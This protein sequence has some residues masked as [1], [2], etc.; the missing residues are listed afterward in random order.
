MS[1]TEPGLGTSKGKRNPKLLFLFLSAIILLGTV[2]GVLYH[3][4]QQSQVKSTTR[5]LTWIPHPEK[6]P[7]WKRDALSACPGAPF[8][9]PTE[10]YIGYLWGDSFRPGHLH[11]GVDIFSGQEPGKM[12]VYAVYQGYLT[13]LPAW[14]SSLI[15]R[16]PH[17]PLRPD[18]QI[19]TYYTHLAGPEGKSYIN[20]NFPP[21]TRDVFVEQGALLGY[22]GNFSGTPGKPVG[23]HLHFSIVKDDG[24]GHFKNE[25]EK[26][27]T[28]DPSPYFRLPLNI[29]MEPDFPITS[30]LEKE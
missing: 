27:N 10:G 30:C 21:G 15:V 24:Q 25:L 14:K 18:R 16:L 4:L 2:L 23:V 26:D 13:R 28:L 8:L 12:P 9:F 1:R 3:L 7:H 17:D 20:D 29:A 11:Q 5:L 6:Y 19:W 22:Q